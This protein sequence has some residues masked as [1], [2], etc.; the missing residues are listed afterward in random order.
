MSV[1]TLITL[2]LLAT[3]GIIAW[4]MHRSGKRRAAL[5]SGNDSTGHAADRALSAASTPSLDNARK[6][7]VIG[8]SAVGPNLDEFDVCVLD[9]HI[10]RAGSFE[11]FELE[12]DRGSEKLWLTVEDD[13][14]REISATVRAPKP[15]ELGLQQSEVQGWRENPPEGRTLEFAGRQHS[16]SEAG[17][18]QYFRS[19]KREDEQR[20]HYWDFESADE[21]SSIAVSLWDDG[22]VEVGYSLPLRSDS[23]VVYRSSEKA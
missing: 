11:W 2:C 10:Y 16:F 22:S 6:G 4:S 5:E 12:C 3:T 23:I 1:V 13:D 14:E 18:A 9:R 8:L 21:K 7:A 17:R 19:G 20:F 15:G